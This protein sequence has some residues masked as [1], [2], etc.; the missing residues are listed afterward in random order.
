[1]KLFQGIP[2]DKLEDLQQTIL[3]KFIDLIVI[4]NITTNFKWKKRF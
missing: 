1:M 2:L 4:N 3:I